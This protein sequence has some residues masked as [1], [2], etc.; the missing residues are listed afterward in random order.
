[1]LAALTG[2]DM[3]HSGILTRAP[4]PRLF[5]TDASG[6][7]C[8]RCQRKH[9]DGIFAADRGIRGAHEMAINER[10]DVLLAIDDI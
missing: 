2:A 3:D 1:M 10:E 7:S 6:P 5:A 8:L 4:P 9:T